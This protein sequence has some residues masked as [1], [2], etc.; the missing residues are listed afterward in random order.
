MAGHDRRPI[1]RDH[2]GKSLLAAQVYVAALGKIAEA[3][4][5]GGMR[6]RS[7]RHR[8]QRP[9][10]RQ[11]RFDDVAG[12]RQAHQRCLFGRGPARLK[13]VWGD[14]GAMTGK[15]DEARKAYHV[16]EEINA[17]KA[18]AERTA[19]QGAHSRSTE[20]FLKTRELDRAIAEI[21]AW[22]S[23]FPE[24][25]VDGY[26]TYLY[27]R[28]WAA[29]GLYP[30][31][32]ALSE[33]L[34]T[35]NKDSPYIDVMLAVSAKCDLKR[36][37]VEGAAATLSSLVKNYPGSPTVPAIKEA[38]KRLRSGESDPAL[39]LLD[40]VENG[41]YKEVL[42]NIDQPPKEARPHA[43]SVAQAPPFLGYS[44]MF[45]SD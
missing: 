4:V 43:A 32:I 28:Y 39:V 33:Q 5:A 18:L 12:R 45:F 25:K 16:A 14:Y 19:W 7:G 44:R 38:L 6:D 13:R 42:E 3:R 20:Q 8:G 36:G 9:G 29:R 23:D 22:Q 2:L 37:K 15:G 11:G 17:S 35:V 1:A 27:A 30:R 26:V 21:R 10:Q 31:A 24:E 34:L 41:N 40:A